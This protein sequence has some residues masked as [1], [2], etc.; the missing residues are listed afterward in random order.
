MV[1]K[2]VKNIAVD[3]REVRAAHISIA[4]AVLIFLIS[5]T[6][7]IMVDSVAL[8]LD[9]G[10]GLVILLMAFFVRAIIN[11]ISNPPDHRYNFG[12]EKYEPLT[13]AL[14]NS[15]IIFTCVL[16]LVFAVQDIVHP[17]DVSRYDLPVAATFLCTVIALALA[18]YLWRVSKKIGSLMLGTSAKQ[19]FI[20]SAL[21]AGMFVG[22]LAGTVLLKLGYSNITPYLDPGMAIALALVLMKFPLQA[23]TG[24]MCELLDGVPA[25][26]IHEKIA[27]IV[28]KHKTNF[29][30]L[31][32][33]R[34]RKA[35][36]KTF[37]D[38]GFMVHG[39]L[40]ME[41]AQTLAEDFEQELARE[42]PSCDVVVYFKRAI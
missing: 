12:Y 40:T 15:A 33:M 14:Q 2:E 1:L 27:K 34:A 25:P 21:S 8:L 20:D 38:I 35:G 26:D 37:L 4:G 28:E 11:K 32:R 10:T 5:L 16:G 18:F 9:A 19:W 7:G 42:V 6:I 29:L 39:T 17:E 30:G 3:Q 22:F 23:L 13:V 41:Q 24:N 36:R 31:H